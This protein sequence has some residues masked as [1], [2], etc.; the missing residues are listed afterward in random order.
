MRSPL[1][2]VWHGPP[3]KQ[4]SDKDADIEQNGKPKHY[5]SIHILQFLSPI[6]SGSA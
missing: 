6:N 2:S 5:H 1:I 3:R 4:S